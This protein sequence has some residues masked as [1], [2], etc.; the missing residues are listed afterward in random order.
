[1]QMKSGNQQKKN[2]RKTRIL[3]HEHFGSHLDN[4]GKCINEELEKRNFQK[5]D[6]TLANI[7]M[8]INIDN[9][10]V[11]AIYKHPEECLPDPEEPDSKWYNK[12]V[13]ESQYFLQVNLAVPVREVP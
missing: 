10:D 11:S 12:H 13:R 2:S 3:P 1:M 7:W 8:E 9:Y 6:E 4:R 5:A